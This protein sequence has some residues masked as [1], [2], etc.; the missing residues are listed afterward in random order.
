M[1]KSKILPYIIGVVTALVFAGLCLYIFTPAINAHNIGLWFIIDFT[2]LI[3]TVVVG[4]AKGLLAVKK[5][6]SAKGK[7][8]KA[9]KFKTEFEF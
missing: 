8:R 6:T 4:L 2:V 1:K 3:F 5:R 9:S 7:N